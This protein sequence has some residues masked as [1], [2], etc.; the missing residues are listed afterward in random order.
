MSCAVV[1]L[2]QSSATPH[3]AH[4]QNAH[5][6]NAHAHNAHAYNAHA[7]NAHAYNAHAYNAHAHTGTARPPALPCACNR[8][9][10]GLRYYV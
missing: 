2:P 5:A 1:Q 3:C 9:H 10:S 8:A 6:Y 4:A 7:H